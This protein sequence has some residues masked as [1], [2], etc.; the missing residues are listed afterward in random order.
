LI[1]AFETLK[2]AQ[3]IWDITA[4]ASVDRVA[5]RTTARSALTRVA[6][7]FD[8]AQ[9]DLVRT[10]HPILRFANLTGRE[11]HIFSGFVM[12]R[13]A[14]NDFALIEFSHFNCQLA[15]S[16]FIEE[17]PIPPDAEQVGATWKRANKDGSRDRR[18]NDNYQ[19]PVMRYGALVLTSPTGLGEVYQVSSY[20]KAASF[21]WALDE[22]K[23][24]LAH[25]TTPT[26]LPALPA[27]VED[28]NEVEGI[29]PGQAPKF[30]AKPRKNLAADWLALV[31]LVAGFT[32]GGGWTVLNWRQIEAA[33]W[34]SPSAPRFSTPASVSMPAQSI[35]HRR[36]H[37]R[38]HIESTA[39]KHR[40]A[41]ALIDPSL[42]STLPK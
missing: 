6:V 30:V 34:A 20:D 25:L 27:S 40:S 39:G 26:D 22:H 31:T 11:L 2:S 5:Q 42:V 17:G 14:S 13:E 3:R 19:I 23:H 1:T 8:F 12:M 35:R 38:H 28:G 9:S 21:A 15:N 33:G 32:F 24:S 37:R 4:M 29:D 41:R 16:N 18:F 10:Q 7:K 36:Y